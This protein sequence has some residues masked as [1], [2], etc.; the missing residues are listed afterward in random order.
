MKLCDPKYLSSTGMDG[1]T[2]ATETKLSGRCA[3]VPF[4]TAGEPAAHAERNAANSGQ[5]EDRGWFMAGQRRP[6][7]GR[8]PAG[9]GLLMPKSRAAG[10][11]LRTPRTRNAPGLPAGAARKPFL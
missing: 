5:G 3:T 8:A 2:S 11:I 10:P 4:W 7:P 9:V 6:A 1:S